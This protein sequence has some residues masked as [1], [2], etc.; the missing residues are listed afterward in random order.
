MGLAKSLEAWKADMLDI[1]KAPVELPDWMLDLFVT[2]PNSNV[3]AI[4]ADSKRTSPEA[5]HRMAGDGS[6]RV[7]CN[8]AQNRHCRPETLAAIFANKPLNANERLLICLARNPNCPAETLAELAKNSSVGVSQCVADHHN[9]PE[10]TLHLLALDLSDETR[11]RV[12]MNPNCPE[13]TL[14]GLSGDLN[15]RVR[16][17]ASINLL[18]KRREPK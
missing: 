8:L 10:S 3:R 13:R 1:Q 16:R 6:L 7:L 2:D 12:A 17:I 9:C 5:L 15:Q 4:I 11:A 14:T 18:K